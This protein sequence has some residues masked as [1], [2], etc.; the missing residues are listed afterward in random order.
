M[1]IGRAL[2]NLNYSPVGARPSREE[3]EAL[4]EVQQPN[5]P[6]RNPARKNASSPATEKQIGFAR[7]LIDT[8]EEGS[9]VAA[10]ILGS[11]P[12]ELADKATVSALIEDL[13][14]R[15]EAAAKKVT[16]SKGQEESEWVEVP[17]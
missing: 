6:P 9:E 15:K 11:E 7:L 5:Y 10:K 4:T 17:F 8:V 16:R 13:K 14:A 12:L 1:S 3:M 2:A